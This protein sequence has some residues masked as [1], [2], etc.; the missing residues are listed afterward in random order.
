MP[1]APAAKRYHSGVQR[2]IERNPE[3]D[4]LLVEFLDESEAPDTVPRPALVAAIAERMC[5]RDE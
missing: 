5:E 4:E 3:V 2:R 1:A